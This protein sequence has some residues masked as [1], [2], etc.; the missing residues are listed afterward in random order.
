MARKRIDIKEFREKGYL[1]EVNRK[2]FHPL[3]LALEVKIDSDGNESLG[4]IWDSRDD[5]E[6]FTFAGL[7][8]EDCK[9]A[10]DIEKEFKIKEK[11]R[12]E[13]LGFSIQPA[14]PT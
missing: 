9:K 5:P 1:Q 10:A 7:N 3:G 11:Y 14:E 8:E 2:F 13:H 6:G 4:G 12:E